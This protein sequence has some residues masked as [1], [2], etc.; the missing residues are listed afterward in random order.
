MRLRLIESQRAT[1]RRRFFGVGFVSLVIHTALIVGA[2]YATLHATQ[3]DNTVKV[4]TTLVLLDAH[5]QQK[6]P[7]PEQP[8]QLDAP[9]RGFQ[10]VTV[11]PEIPATLPPLNLQEPFDP[12]DYTGAGVEG[13][14]GTGIL[15]GEN[16]IYAEAVV[17]EKPSLLSGPPPVYP[18]LLKQAGIQGRV[19]VRA[20]IDT[21]GRVDPGSVRIVKSPNPGFNEPTKQWVL[22][23]LFR[24]ARIH[25]QAVRVIV[26]L[27]FDYSLGS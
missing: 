8:A 2:V 11:V 14:T 9:L 16:Q 10:T 4:D 26:N 1:N 18:S 13:G 17:E 20:V 23:A 27:P 25:G 7:P 24:P 19:V 3:S 22:K 12:K 6:P 5:Q 15:P 21:T